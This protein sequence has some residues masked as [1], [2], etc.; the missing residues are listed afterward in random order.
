MFL[1]N[2]GQ[3]GFT[4]MEAVAGITIFLVAMV[5]VTLVFTTGGR[6][7]R[8]STR[9][10]EANDLAAEKL[11][12]ISRLP[13]F[14][15][16]NP[17]IGNQDI[18]DF[19][20]NASEINPN[21]LIGAGYSTGGYG[22]IDGFPNHRME[23]WVQYQK[24]DGSGQLDT[25]IPGM[26]TGWG[27]KT[28][29]NDE[30]FDSISE[31]LW[32]ILVRVNVHYRTDTGESSVAFED[33]VSE[34]E[35]R[36]VP[37]VDSVSPNGFN[38]GSPLTFIVYGGGFSDDPVNPAIK[39]TVRAWKIGDNPYSPVAVTVDGATSNASELHCQV[40]INQ[41]HVPPD[42]IYW[43]I[44]VVNTDNM[45]NMLNNCLS[46]IVNP[47]FIASVIPNSGDSGDWVEVVGSDF[48]TK[49]ASDYVQ[50]NGVDVIDYDNPT[51]PGNPNWNN[52]SIWV[53]VPATATTGHVVVHKYDSGDSNG[54]MFTVTSGGLVLSY[55]ENMESGKEGESGDVGDTVRVYGNGFAAVQGASVVRFYNGVDAVVYSIWSDSMI[56]CDVP[57]GATTGMAVVSIGGTVDSNA[58]NFVIPYESGH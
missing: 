16:Y 11:E 21:Q 51:V 18:D 14:V 22:S 32:L 13:F 20:Y 49:G 48:G 10:S 56:E 1:V 28:I 45:A 29:G 12:E 42:D 6:A 2:K 50:F 33:M 36:Y 17:A 7:I 57:V 41:A 31:R 9:V 54:I 37:R 26:Q 38:L 27:P 44:T 53:K 4:S 15:E 39:P 35:I 34:K 30:P 23:I 25:T 43:N 8:Q 5:G 47:P 24:I 55:F 52:N 40:T 46:E 3:R 58:V 19:Y